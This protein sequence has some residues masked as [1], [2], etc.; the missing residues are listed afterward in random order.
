MAAPEPTEAAAREARPSRVRA[1]MRRRHNWV[2]LMKFCAVGGS[3]YVVN[4]AVFALAFSVLGWHHLLAA[5]AAFVV[6]VTNNFYW[7]RYWTFAARDG[8]AGFQAARFYTVS[9]AAF[10]FAATVLELLVTQAG[11]PKWRHRRSRWLRPRRSTSWGT[12]RGLRP[13][14]R[15]LISLRA[16]ILALALCALAGAL[17]SPASGAP[18]LEAPSSQTEPPRGY[19]LDA[20]DAKRIAGQAPTIRAERPRHRRFTPTA[21]T[22][23][24]GRW[25][26][27]FFD[28]DDEVAQ[29]RID[30][31]PARCWSSGPANRWPGR[32]PAAMRARS[33]GR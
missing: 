24:P 21:Y 14:A 27:S 22:R 26:V 1:G 18:A 8:H 33:G 30:D 29:V 7:N 17:A 11:V 25:Q 4:L 13:G 12:R 32:W 2:Q 31:A 5:T 28:G 9:V 6:A 20:T 19:R 10:V 3:G 16:L 23:G 15:R